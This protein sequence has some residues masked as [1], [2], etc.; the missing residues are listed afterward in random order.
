MEADIV[1]GDHLPDE[2]THDTDD[3]GGDSDPDLPEPSRKRTRIYR[4]QSRNRS[5][6]QQESAEKEGA[7]SAD[8]RQTAREP[9][10]TV[11]VTDAAGLPPELQY[12]ADTRTELKVMV[13]YSPGMDDDMSNEF[14]ATTIRQ[15]AMLS[16]QSGLRAEADGVPRDRD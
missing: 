12:P 14:E 2:E 10:L 6:E 4:H 15:L 13:K 1:E 11:A 8:I 5:K 3:V 7:R 9:V 16:L